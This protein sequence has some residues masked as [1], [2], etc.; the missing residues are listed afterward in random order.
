[1]APGFSTL[2]VV[3]ASRISGLWIIDHVVRPKPKEIDR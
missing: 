2:S 1:M 3:E